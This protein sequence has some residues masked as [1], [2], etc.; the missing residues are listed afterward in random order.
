MSRVPRRFRQ[1]VPSGRSKRQREKTGHGDAPTSGLLE[2]GSLSCPTITWICPADKLTER[3]RSFDS[4]N[5]PDYEMTGSSKAMTPRKAA[6]L[7]LIAFSLLLAYFHEH[8]IALYKVTAVYYSWHW[9]NQSELSMQ[10]DGFDT[11]FARYNVGQT[12]SLP[13]DQTGPAVQP[14]RASEISSA[15]DLIPPVLHHILLGMRESAMPDSWNQSRQSCM[16]MHHN[17]TTM[18][19]DDDKA[20]HFLTTHYPWFMRQYLGYRYVIQRADALRYFVL[21]HYGGVF[22]DLDLT[23]RRGLGPLR[24]FEVVMIGATP[25]GVSNGFMMA[26]PRHPFFAQLIK[27]LPLYDLNFLVSYA[28]I[29]FST[30]PMFLSAEHL[31]YKHRSQL[32]YLTEPFHHLSG[33]VITPL[34]EHAG[35]S[36]WH[37]DDAKL[38]KR[39]LA[40]TSVYAVGLSIISGVLFAICVVVALS[41]AGWTGR[42]RW[43]VANQREALGM[44]GYEILPTHSRRSRQ[45]LRPI[46]THGLRPP[47]RTQ[48]SDDG[49]GV[50]YYDDLLDRRR[51]A[52]G[53]SS[54]PISA[55]D[56]PASFEP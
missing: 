8:V 14:L 50:T 56:V 27:A 55:V 5:R 54:K 15:T 18:L 29:M 21:Y 22:L 43:P 53:D 23:C 20:T 4:D 41:W 25:S 19:W 2:L 49:E 13:W 45:S 7:A 16:D 38:I 39:L 42:I 47:S 35:S 10:A 32:K 17:W 51:Q 48:V 9:G 37:Q 1:S 36:S 31:R 6:I 30:G 28:S 24:S 34:F 3:T 11:T 52:Q 26:A 44:E 40:W 12:T 46:I 33:R